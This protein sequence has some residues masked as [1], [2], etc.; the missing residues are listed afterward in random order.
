MYTKPDMSLHRRHA[1]LP[2]DGN[3]SVECVSIRGRAIVSAKKYMNVRVE[4]PANDRGGRVT[5]VARRSNSPGGAK[6][7]VKRLEGEQS[8]RYFPW[9]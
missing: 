8:S 9:Y 3:V 2:Y 7:G 4:P 5:S 1:K 6:R